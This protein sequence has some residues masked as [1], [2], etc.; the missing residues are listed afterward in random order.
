MDQTTQVTIDKIYAQIGGL[1]EQ[2]EKKQE[3]INMLY[4]MEGEP[5]AFP[6]IG[7]ARASAA[8]A[9]RGDQFFGKPLA[10][11]VKEILEQRWG[12]KLGAM[13]LNE[14]FDVM[15]AGG[16]DFGN[17]DDKIARRNLSIALSKNPHFM[18]VPANNHIGLTEWYPNVKR[19]KETKDEEVSETSEPKGPEED[20][21]KA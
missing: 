5:V 10:T 14:L 19:K 20:E 13:S 11:A 6:N 4:E 7:A 12:R 17:S 8:V 21:E 16:F 2:I 3:A 1:E 18:R 9:F 15:K